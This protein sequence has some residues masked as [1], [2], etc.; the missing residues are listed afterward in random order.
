MAPS[1][2]FCDIVADRVPSQKVY[3]DRSVL[4][5]HDR[6][7]QAPVHLVIVP[8]RHIQSVSHAPDDARTA[9]MFARLLLA[10][11]HVAHELSLKK[12]GYRLVINNGTDAGQAVQHL[13]VHVLAGRPLA[14]PPG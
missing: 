12:N 9:R 14:W 8:K 11:R 3:E 2:I 10:A 13:H 1:C 5:F 7:P 4:V 6:H